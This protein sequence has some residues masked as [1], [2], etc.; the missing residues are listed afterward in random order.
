MGDVMTD[1]IAMI[2]DQDHPIGRFLLEVEMLTLY[3]FK[4]L[5]CSVS[6]WNFILNFL[7]TS[8]RILSSLLLQ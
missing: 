5:I 7:F 6:L 4:N 1:T 3:S 8:P 2:T